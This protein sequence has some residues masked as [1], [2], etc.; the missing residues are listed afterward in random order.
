M[1]NN[2][3]LKSQTRRPCYRWLVAFAMLLLLSVAAHAE[4][5]GFMVSEIPDSVF[6][7][8]KGKSY[9]EGCNIKLSELRLLTLLYVD[10]QGRKKQGTM[11]CNRL[12]AND[13]VSIFRELYRQ[14]YPIHSIRLVDEYD[15]SDE[16]SMEANNT[17]C[18]NYRMTTNG[19]LS[20]HARGMAVDIN[21]LW[22]PCIHITGK[23]AGK[24]EPR[25]A[26]RTHKIDKN[27]LC[28]RLFIQ[29]G[30]KWGGA[31][32]SLKDYQHFEK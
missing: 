28:Y 3:K 10:E 4:N 30:F 15:A 29:H 14:R 1:K 24:I 32:R 16:R 25:N 2:R 12:I 17:S 22:N 8:M 6:V 5:D 7:K 27:D 11:I 20:K 18:F 31:W 23:H 19:S 9:P 13:L 26:R 21:P